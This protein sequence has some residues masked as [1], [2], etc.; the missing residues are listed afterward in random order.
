MKF[1]TI[2]E[3][4][5]ELAILNEKLKNELLNPYIQRLFEDRVLQLEL[6]IYQ[7]KK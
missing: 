2:D 5:E 7:M 4:E 3:S 1:V 6:I